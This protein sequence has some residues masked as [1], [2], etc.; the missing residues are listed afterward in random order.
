MA[1]VVY[2]AI[3][4]IFETLA[5]FESGVANVAAIVIVLAPAM[6]EVAAVMMRVAGYVTEVAAIMMVA[7]SALFPVV[8]FRVGV[9][10]GRQHG[11][12]QRSRDKS[13]DNDCV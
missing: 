4:P 13:R 6:A 11:R 2:G 10:R 12:D 3:M 1:A 9:G 5:I 8:S 7:V